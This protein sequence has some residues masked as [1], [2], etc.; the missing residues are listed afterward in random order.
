WGEVR[1]GASPTQTLPTSGE[2][3]RPVTTTKLS[4]HPRRSIQ[5]IRAVL[6]GAPRDFCGHFINCAKQFR[7]F[8]LSRQQSRTAKCFSRSLRR[9]NHLPRA[10]LKDKGSGVCWHLGEFVDAG[11]KK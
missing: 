9:Q 7:I 10:H 5:K 3:L 8:D 2:G 1:A 11:E 6:C 4:D